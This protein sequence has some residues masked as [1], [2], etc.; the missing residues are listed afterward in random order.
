MSNLLDL[1]KNNENNNISN[2]NNN[3]KDI[4][5]DKNEKQLLKEKENYDKRKNINMENIDTDVEENNINNNTNDNYSS[6]QRIISKNITNNKKN[7]SQAT[8]IF[9]I[10]SISED[11]LLK[12]NSIE[13]LG[14]SKNDKEIKIL[15]KELID[16]KV[17]NNINFI[18]IKNY[19]KGFD[20]KN[21]YIVKFEL[22]SNND[23]EK[24]CFK[25]LINNTEFN[26]MEYSIQKYEQLFIYNDLN[27]NHLLKK[28]KYKI[29]LQQKFY[30]FERY[31][32]NNKINFLVPSLLKDTLNPLINLEKIDIEFILYYLFILIDYQKVYSEMPEISKELFY[33]VIINIKKKKELFINFPLKHE[34]NEIIKIIENYSFD[35]DEEFFYKTIQ[36]IKKHKK[37]FSMLQAS[38]LQSI[39]NISNN[40][41]S[42]NDLISIIPNYNEYLKFI[43][44]NCD[45]ILSNKP[46]IFEYPPPDDNIE[47]D[48]L[49]NFIEIILNMKLNKKNTIIFQSQL[50]SLINKLNM[51]NYNKLFI[52]REIIMKYK[53]NDI[54]KKPLNELN[55]AIHITG[56][57]F[58]KNKKLENL[59]II[60]FIHK[61]AEVFYK[62][63]ENNYEYACLISYIDINKIDDKF[64]NEFIGNNYDYKKLFKK[65]YP[66]FLSSITQRVEYFEQLKTLYK[67]FNIDNNPSSIKEII[68]HLIET[69]NSNSLKVKNLNIFNLSEII[70]PLYKL[71][72]DNNNYKVDSLI[73]A[74]KRKFS[75]KEINDIFIIFLNNFIDQL[76]K[77]M[78]KKLIINTN[79]SNSDD[80]IINL[81]QI[82]NIEIKKKFLQRLDKKVLKENEIFRKEIS[83]N[84][85]LLHELINMKYFDYENNNYNI[86]FKDIHYIKSTTEIMKCLYEKLFQFDFSLDEMKILNQ[87]INEGKLMNRIHLVTLGKESLMNILYNKLNNKINEYIDI[88]NKVNEIIDVYSYYF[89]NNKANLIEYYKEFRER[90]IHM[91]VNEFPQIKE[92]KNFNESYTEVHQITIYKSS[93]FFIEIFQNLSSK[94]NNDF[95]EVNDNILINKTKEEFLKLKNLFDEKTENRVDL[96]LL[97]DIVI[98]INNNDM[99]NQ[100]VN[101]SY[102]L[103][104]K[105]IPN[106]LCKK[107][108]LLNNRKNNIITLNNIVLLLYDFKIYINKTENHISNLISILQKKE[109]LNDLI[110]VELSLQKLNINI[111]NSDKYFVVK[112]VINKMYIKPELIS[113]LINKKINDIHSMGEFIDDS[114]NEFLSLSDIDQLETCA[115]FIHE[116]K[117]KSTSLN[118]KTFLDAFLKLVENENYKEIDIKFENSS[119]KYHD[120]CELFTSHLN[121]NELNKKHIKEIYQKSLFI[122]KPNECIIEYVNNRKKITK[123]FEEILDLRDVALLR[124]KDQKESNYFKICETFAEIISDIQ[125]ILKLINI[126]TLKGYYKEIKFTIR[127]AD[128]KSY[129]C[130]NSKNEMELKNIINYLN[131]IKKVQNEEVKNIYLLN[132]IV[133]L[134]YGRQFSYIYQ[135]LITNNNKELNKPMNNNILNNI[136]KYATNNKN[137]NYNDNYNN[138]NMKNINKENTQILLKEMYTTVGTYLNE[139][140]KINNID[141]KS[142]YN[143]SI[144]VNGSKK[145]IF[146]Y[147]SQLENIERNAIYCSLN[148]TG[149]FPIAQTVLL[150]NCN[151][152]E[153]EITSFTYRS[154]KCKY[155]TLFL[156]IKPENLSLEKKHLLIEL[157]K[158]IYSPN[159][160]CINSCIIFIY[161]NKNKTN[162]IITEIEKL[163]YHKYFDLK[164]ENNNERK[165]PNIEIYSSEFS[166]L[167]KSTLIKSN[168]K[169]ED[170]NNEYD[171][172]YFP[173]GGD[174]NE[175]EIFEKV[176]PFTDKKIALHLDLYDTEQIELINEFL[177]SFLILRCYSKN[178]TVFYYGNN[179]R[180]KVE[181]PNSF[182]DFKKIFPIFGFFKNIH[183]ASDKML[184]L[185]VPN[186]IYSNVQIV[187]N[188]LK[189]INQ[190][191]TSD[192]FIEEI[193]KI[194]RINSINAVP[195]SQTECQRLIFENLNINKPNYYQIESFMKILSEQFILLSNSIYLNANHINSLS[196]IKKNLNNVRYFFVNSLLSMTKHFITSSYD[197]ILKSQ[198]ITY[199]HQKGEIDI[200][201][202]NERAI[203]ILTEKEPFSIDNIKPSMI[204]INE[205]FQSISEIVT[206]EEDTDEYRLLKAIYNSD[207]HEEKRNVLDYKNL[208]S[209]E[210]LVEVKKVLNINNPINELDKNSPKIL[211]GKQLRYLNDITKSYVF[212]A[213]NFIKL[214]IISL[215]LR[216]NIP[217]I[218]MGETGCGK[219]SLIR[220][221]AELKDIELNSLNIHAGIEDKDIIQFIRN[222]NLFENRNLNTNEKINKRSNNNIWVFLDEI[223]TCNSL[224]LITEIMLKHSCN[225]NKIKDNVKFIA[226]CNPY[227]LNTKNNE[228]I[229]LYDESKHSVRKLVYS[230]NPIPIPLLNFVFDFGTPKKDDIKRYI[231]NMVF[232]ILQSLI[233]NNNILIEI[234]RIAENAIFEAHKFIQ[235][236]YEISSVSLRE[237]RRWGILYE[238]FVQLLK[239]NL[240]VK[241]KLEYNDES[242]YLYSLN[243]SIYL[244]YFIR[245]FNKKQREKF[246]QLMKKAFEEKI[247]FESFPRKFQEI[248]ATAV[249]LEIGIAKNRALLENLFSIFVCLNTKIPL[250]II[251]KP[252]CSKSLSAQLIF[253]SMNGKNSRNEFFKSFPKVYTKSY[254]GSLTSNSKGVLK[255]FKKARDS[256]KDKELAKE[257]ISVIYFD[258]MGLAEIS[259]NNPLKVIHSQLEYDENQEKVSF[260]GI[261]NWPLDASKMNRGI[262]L[263]I[264]EPDKNDLIETALCIA[265]SYD[266][267]LIHEYNQYFEY[268]ALTYFDYKKELNKNSFKFESITNLDFNSNQANKKEFHGTRDFYH[269]IK[270]ASKLLVKSNFTKDTNYIESILN[271]SIERN[272]GGLD[273]SIRIFKKLFKNYVPFINEINEYDVI[274]CIKDNIQ[275]TKSRYL[276]I[277]TKSSISHFLITLIL[278]KMKKD[279][280]FYY[281]SN[282]EEDTLNGY[283]S[284]KVLNKVQVTM[285]RDNVMIL[286]NLTSMYPSLYDLFNQNFRKV[287][288]S[289]YARI[290]LGNSNTQ[291]YFVNNNFR[292]IVLLDKSE[293]DNQ[294]PPFINRFEKHIMSFKFLLNKYQIEIAKQV[295]ELINKLVKYKNI[296]IKIDLYHELINCDLE[297]IQGI[298]YQYSIKYKKEKNIGNAK[299]GISNIEEKINE[300]NYINK[301][302]FET[303]SENILQNI[304]PT[305]SQDII[306]YAKNSIF[307]KNHNKE[308]QNILYIYLKNNCRNIKTYLKNIDSPKHIIYTFSNI[309]DSIFE[310]SESK[311]FN[312][313]Y[314]VFNIKSTRNIFIKEYNSERAIDD[315][316]IDFY[317]NNNNNLCIFHF[318]SKDI[319]HLNHINNLIINNKYNIKDSKNINMKVIIF[320]IHLKRTQNNNKNE[321]IR[322]E[323]FISHLTEWKQLFIDNLNGMDIDFNEIFESSTIE[324]INNNK[325]I[326]LDDEF[327]KDLF[328]AFTLIKYN[329]KIN[330]SNIKNTQYIEKI[331]IQNVIL[332]K[333]KSIKEN[334]IMKIFSEYNFDDDDVDFISIIIKYLKT[335]YSEALISTLIQFEN[336]N[337]LSTKMTEKRVMKNEFFNKIY[338]N[339]IENFDIK[340]EKYSVFSHVVN[341]NLILGVSY[342]C[343]ISVF[344]IINNYTNSLISKYLEN[345][346]KYRFQQIN[347]LNEYFTE[348]TNLE[349]NLKI[350]F[351]RQYIEKIFDNNA[352]EDLDIDKLTELLFKDYNIYYLSKSN[353]CF[354]N[355]R[356]L[357]FFKSLYNLLLSRDGNEEN[358]TKNL[359]FENIVKYILFIESYKEYIYPLCEFLCTMDYYIKD[360]INIF[361][362]KILSNNFKMLNRNISYV[363]DIFYNLF[364]S[365]VYCILST[366]NL[367][368]MSNNYFDIILNNINI[369]S[370]SLMKVNIELRLTLKQILYLQDFLNVYEEF[371]KNGIPLKENLN[372]YLKL[373]QKE[374]EAYL[375][376]INNNAKS[377]ISSTKEEIDK[378]FDFLKQ[379]LSKSKGYSDLIVRLLN[380]KIKMSK[381]E[382]YRVKL[383]NILCSNNSFIFKSKII[384]E[385]ILRKYDIIPINYYQEN[386]DSSSEDE[387]NNIHK[388]NYYSENEFT[389]EESDYEESY[390]DESDNYSIDDDESDE[391]SDYEDSEDENYNAIGLRFLSQLK[392]DKGNVII[393]FLNKTNNECLDEI[394]LLLFDGK[395]SKYFDK[396]SDTKNMILNQSFYIFQKCINFIEEDNFKV[397]KTNKLGI[398][399]CISY[400]KYYCFHVCRIMYNENEN[401]EISKTEIFDFLNKPSEFRKIIK[402]YIL[403]VLNLIVIK[404]YSRF[405]NFIKIKKLFI[406]DF[407][408]NEKI[409]CT[410]NYLF[411]HNKTFDKYKELRNAFT[412]N[413]FEKFKS[414]NSILKVTEEN[415]LD[416]YNLLI[417]EIVSNLLVSYNK[418]D[419]AILSNYINEIISKL[420]ISPISSRILSL[421]F[422]INFLSNHLPSIQKLTPEHF[423]VL[424]YSHKWAFICSL[425]KKNSVY[426]KILSPTVKMD[427]NNIYIPGGE[428]NNCLLI[429]SYDQIEKFINSGRSGAIYMCSCYSW[430]T[431]GECGRPMEKKICRKCGNEIG[432]IDHRLIDR[433]GHV[434]IFIN[435]NERI[436]N[437]DGTRFKMLRDL[438]I[439]ANN[440]RNI[441]VK[442]FK[443]VDKSFFLDKNKIVR[444]ISNITY[445]VLSFIFYSCIL[446]NEKLEHLTKNDMKQFYLSD[447][448]QSILSI[449]TDIWKI[450]IEELS[451]KGIDNI[452]CF[453]NMIIPDISQIISENNSGMEISKDR[454]NFEQKCNQIIDLAINNYRYYQKDYMTN[455]K[456][457][458]EI[459]DDTIKS[460]L[461]ETSNI[462][463]L[464]SETYPLIK[465][466]NAADYPNYEKFFEQFNS[467][468]NCVSQYPVITNYINATQEEEKFQFLENFHLINPFVNYLL[469][470]Y[471]NKISRKKAKEKKLYE[472]FEDNENNNEMKKLYKHFK[473]G[474]RN[475][476]N[477]LSNYDCNGQLPPKN[478]S[479]KDCL[480]FFLNDKFE[481]NY[482]K[483][484][485]TAYKDF[486]TYQNEFLKPLI[487]DNSNNEY[488]YAYSNQI[489]KE[490]VIQRA[491]KKEVVSLH[492]ENDLFDSFE[493]II[494]SFS[495]RNY[496]FNDKSINYLNYKEIKFDF[497]SIEMELTK[498]L[499]PEKRL[500][501]NEDNQD[502][503][504]YAFEGFNQNESIILDYKEKIQK[505]KTLTN[506]EKVNIAKH[507]KKIDYNVILFNLQSLL[508]YM[509]NAKNI[510]GNEKL[511]DE[512]KKLPNKVI[513][514]DYE[515]IKFFEDFQFEITLNQLID[516]YEYIELL[517]YSKILKNVSQK[518]KI[519][520][521]DKEQ[522]EKLQIHFGKKDLL[523]SKKDLGHAV[524]KFISRYL[525]SDRFKNFDWN[526]FVLLK[527]KSELWSEHIVSEENERIFDNEIEQLE[528]FDIRIE[529]SVDFYENLRDDKVEKVIKTQ[530]FKKE[531]SKF[532]DLNY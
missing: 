132:D 211:G 383:L 7:H 269:L 120:F 65:Q 161:N 202:A 179:I 145:G 169:K 186:N 20:E 306:F 360:F 372:I 113:F 238:W 319:I 336:H 519:I 206:C 64:C 291:N 300:N 205:D 52:L 404:N 491:N 166:G 465:Y 81:N 200:I 325:L 385:T 506:E 102:I 82:E 476:Y 59:E 209:E 339:F 402:I 172:H 347:E 310:T 320:I 114:E 252:G 397:T 283:Y 41:I 317:S 406:N 157:L 111:S 374:N 311:I 516:C 490:V 103:D 361:I 499:L 140:Y 198:N 387:R 88:Y 45:Y 458:L 469:S 10:I 525:V 349:C 142:I 2:E 359:T 316:I 357:K 245:I 487:K 304:V 167:G 475:I 334:I 128:G 181:I 150:C 192:I 122:L 468:N 163:P 177:F 264:P 248:I 400:I 106:N 423:E 517:N 79:N 223:N 32:S 56:K 295:F 244:C 71:V 137:T 297:E 127:I 439:E 253:K 485:A 430:Y 321:N 382:E 415:M 48:L 314:G 370:H 528:S 199:S 12:N 126:I 226:A 312:K 11:T 92:I 280:V 80:I 271:E 265:K 480:A 481:N 227:R 471:N 408:F 497:N 9:F 207:S 193:S 274:Q 191:N 275:D 250:F 62:E 362:S 461:Q 212:T 286:K 452:Q 531:K 277:E 210:F 486:I 143:K 55:K 444:N 33:T 100:I 93:K 26:K 155:N 58:I 259:K 495:Y 34:Y 505:V 368:Y 377:I 417:N 338:E 49:V 243:L 289:N 526:I 99:E 70:F 254:Q 529:Q 363:N 17:N 190:I 327:E 455:N 509:T 288:E 470:K 388:N 515:F 78:I 510:T 240:Y 215:R 46:E 76:N 63:Y 284:A 130:Q 50:T 453:I 185:N 67:I 332:K 489:K 42:F 309:L 173:L 384:F 449:L 144:I 502:F 225:G 333:I 201:E 460:I 463:N 189:Y 107:I 21:I 474:W 148:L 235:K 239:N 165:Y 281:G 131:E 305:F 86:H 401:N 270:T 28:D 19:E 228:V 208:K 446:Y 164:I 180:I 257:I 394:L 187:S 242:V 350:E 18:D 435:D 308:F 74:T 221:I 454:D 379:K 105:E 233:P 473:K 351:E 302:D 16:I 178:E 136:L 343:I 35:Y 229:G 467:I 375:L 66:I 69:L 231:S 129:E 139:L 121:P 90:F 522:K 168:F 353:K 13:I 196:Q 8:H 125:E 31:I 342:P 256:L 4:H 412:L 348:K 156:I 195:L 141:L 369:F 389:Y 237:I 381:D 520:S 422:D 115:A 89:K 501:L 183:L 266:I 352:N 268:L 84:M 345:E 30:I 197:N 91:K 213:D 420:K 301:Y 366:K 133:R 25:I 232:Q 296:N 98:N 512:I 217:V 282:F 419:Y 153:E 27:M 116:L 322:N 159:P 214:I 313:I 40:N 123:Y 530:K 365:V 29:S 378:E 355:K 393:L 146:S 380:N 442:G 507:I 472:A 514:L 36:Y 119:N 390:T 85:K 395:I 258:E 431:I 437:N 457:I 6:S 23:D 364:E 459:E 53:N 508:L 421:Y 391:Y 492:I 118:E 466:F 409:P 174:I 276:L 371:C 43:C 504:T 429:E 494:Y 61:D 299:N 152:T 493:D 39:F 15:K 298:I 448:N 236:N 162:E 407:D 318:D 326:N 222:K 273:F 147:S 54:F 416:F 112:T 194:D 263:S 396:K 135:Y 331:S 255:I 482:G 438:K 47:I 184:P 60:I 462:N 488:L 329:F 427:I 170:N 37:S 251:G 57:H 104:V 328:H 358:N 22:D 386:E 434:R 109:T 527:F 307:A 72:S 337:I 68:S 230:V 451:N 293:I 220:I 260:I 234:Q 479:K 315:L 188:Y 500:F 356:I 75:D 464:P 340:F 154:I 503:I 414:N 440:K 218:L 1:K 518:V 425:S 303:Y 249:E 287:G 182:I 175:N 290:A 176:L 410:L 247:N 279:H 478:L 433:Q 513:K 73:K 278:D 261:S 83:D 110:D 204:I 24:I 44:L 294:D 405:I 428:P 498:I 441:Q 138:N 124:K 418:E 456:T 532:A 38:H 51:K 262:H 367:K 95:E 246:V 511:V 450:L 432:G 399:Y 426:S 149:N 496:N 344:K 424:L 101:L 267:R 346:N 77:D 203:E 94:A 523:I 87:L 241:N 285:S 335:I 413:K 398:L 330:F 483:Y 484:I 323:Y 3:F 403:K 445:R 224:R 97:E 524:R 447:N 436:Q 443:K 354:S 341:V 96:S 158:E 373:L 219:T 324:L 151:T 477:K 117:K 521:L 134:I 14:C 376:T 171:Y 216:T 272:F 411:I 5:K 292:C 108:T 160:K 392:K